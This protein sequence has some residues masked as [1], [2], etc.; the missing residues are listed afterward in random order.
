MFDGQVLLAGKDGGFKE[1]V[2]LAAIGGADCDVLGTSKANE[3]WMRL[4]CRDLTQPVLCAPHQ[5]DGFRMGNASLG[6][7]KAVELTGKD[8]LGWPKATRM[9]GGEL[10]TEE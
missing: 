7:L 9:I 8:G 10:N 6:Q 5:D 1:R 3:V 2:F 4:K